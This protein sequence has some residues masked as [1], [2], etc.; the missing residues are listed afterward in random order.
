MQPGKLSYAP[1]EEACGIVGWQGHFEA[2][3]FGLHGVEVHSTAAALIWRIGIGTADGLP[4]PLP[5]LIKDAPGLRYTA[6]APRA[7]V[8]PIDGGTLN[9]GLLRELIAEPLSAILL[10]P[11]VGIGHRTVVLVPWHQPVVDG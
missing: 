2:D 5:V 4:L 1:L 6:S 8:V 11:P 10:R 7:V 9:G 3:G